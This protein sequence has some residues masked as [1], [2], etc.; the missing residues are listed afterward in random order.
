MKNT[1]SN[2]FCWGLSII[3]FH[4]IQEWSLLL[5]VLLLASSPGILLCFPGSCDAFRNLRA[6]SAV[7]CS[8]RLF[9]PG[10][11]VDPPPPAAASSRFTSFS[12]FL[13]QVKTRSISCCT[14]ET[15][16]K[17][18][19]SLQTEHKVTKQINRLSLWVMRFEDS[20][21]TFWLLVCPA[22][23]LLVASFP[24]DSLCPP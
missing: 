13:L 1:V 9:L 3:S 20:L 18:L 8:S 10:A 24:M 22:L 11:I 21:L 14:W 23:V 19:R 12:A 6:L 2:V 4:Y 15:K 16:E 7:S 17:Y 5:A